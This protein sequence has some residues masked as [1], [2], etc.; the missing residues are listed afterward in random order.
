MFNVDLTGEF[1]AF[2]I[3]S[4]IIIS[5]AVLMVSFTKVVY[6]VVS[7]AAVFIG[8]A[9]MFILLN[10]EFLAFVQVLIYAGA[11]S[12]LMIFGIMMTR[13]EDS[14]TEKSRPLQETLTAVGALALFGILFYAIRQSDFPVPP[15]ATSAADNTM[16][17]GKQLFTAYVVPFELVSVLLT[18]AFIGAIVLAK[19]EAD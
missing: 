19:K 1:V 10:A 18:V 4:I 15:A 12:I 11:V 5:G 8:I 13:H 9:G 6:M 16:E 17:I 3:F 7:L 14:E 2:F